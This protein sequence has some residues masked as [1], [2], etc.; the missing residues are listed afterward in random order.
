MSK[1]IRD[2]ILKYVI[3][4]HKILWNDASKCFDYMNQTMTNEIIASKEKD[5]TQI[6]ELT[7]KKKEKIK[8]LLLENKG[9]ISLI[10]NDKII[11]ILYVNPHRFGSNN[12]DKVK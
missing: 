4:K 3:C 7:N 5:R 8:A 1:N 9:W 6:S 11:R 12:I 2:I 10:K